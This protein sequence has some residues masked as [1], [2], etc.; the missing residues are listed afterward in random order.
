LALRSDL[1]FAR[2]CE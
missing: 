2:Q 1:A